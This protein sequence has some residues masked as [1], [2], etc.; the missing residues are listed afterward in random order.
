MEKTMQKFSFDS[1]TDDVLAGID[2][3]G[4]NAIV[5]GATSGIGY[6]TARAL[7]AHGANV[8]ITARTLEKGQQAATQLKSDTAKDVDCLALELNKFDTVKKAAQQW[9]GKGKDLHILVNNAG[10]MM[11]PYE[12]TDEGY[13]MQFATN[14]LGHFLFT[15]LLRPALIEAKGARVVNV[16][17]AAHHTD[18]VYFDDINFKAK[19]YSPIAAY[20]Q[21]K[22]ANVWF[23]NEFD[24]RFKDRG[25]RSF[26][27]HPGGIQ[28]N[29]GKHLNEDIMAELM[30]T[31]KRLKGGEPTKTTAQGAA[32]SCWAAASPDLDGKGGLY[33]AN[34]Q[35]TTEKNE[36]DNGHAAHAY[37]SAKS[38]KLWEVSNTMLQTDF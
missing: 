30:A 14:H 23:A 37:D 35:I 20:G 28:T 33:L 19:D 11:T 13:E 22:T 9:L 12:L 5:T 26:S 4:K 1:T 17:S 25:I 7:A 8:T 27:L 31:I 24:K 15:N 3:A 21:S 2:L 6:E 32:T 36:M 10:V 18:E 34:C 16:A 29:L 38:A